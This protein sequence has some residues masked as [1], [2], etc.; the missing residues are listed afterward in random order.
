MF[1]PFSI[2]KM[3]NLVKKVKVAVLYLNTLWVFFKCLEINTIYFWMWTNLFTGFSP[4]FSMIDQIHWKK[5][6]TE[7]CVQEV[8]WVQVFLDTVYVKRC[9][10]S[11]IGQ[12]ER[13]IC[14][15]MGWPRS[16][17][18]FFYKT[19][20][21]VLLGQPNSCKKALSW[22]CGELWSWDG[23]SELS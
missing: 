6:S 22:L 7:I 4:Y 17:F 23:H 21:N 2:S 19:L 12:K 8:D 9:K 20:G 3:K 10:G 18:G 13:L 16:A 5:Y 11:R 15:E 1:I 14:D